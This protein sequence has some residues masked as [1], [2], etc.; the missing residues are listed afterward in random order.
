MSLRS[1]YLPAPSVQNGRIRITGD[2]HRHL[3]VARA[4]KDELIEIFDG[5]GHIWSA[6]IE[7]LDKRETV[8]SVKDSR[9]VPPPSIEL[10]LG[11]A[12]IRIPAFEL[13]LEKVVEVGVTRIVPFTATRS[14]VTGGHRHDR[15]TRVLIE[16]AKQSKH[17]HLP[18]LRAPVSF[19][20]VLS[21]PAASKI[22]FTERKGASLRQALT[23]SPVLYLIGP[24][25]GWT[26]EELA[27]AGEIGLH[28]VSLGDAILKAETAAIAG[29]ALIL[30][31]CQ[32]GP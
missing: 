18:S 32:R 7:S 8:A 21:I 16:A 6:A 28:L 5:N 17:Y 12:L 22:M 2:E 19:A 30:Y 14:N 23:G 20:E 29:A 9:Q 13:A 15:W 10:I 26:D 27:A 1:V 4:E 25:G 31:E 3:V 11:M 24:E